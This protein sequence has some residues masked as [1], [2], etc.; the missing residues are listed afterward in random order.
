MIQNFFKSFTVKFFPILKFSSPPDSSTSL[1]DLTSGIRFYLRQ[2]GQN[3][4][5]IG[6]RLILAKVLMPHGEWQNWL[7][8]NFGLTDRTARNFMSVAKRFGKTKTFAFFPTSTLIKMLA[9]PEGDEEKFIEEQAAEGR[10]VAE[11]SVKTLRVEI[12]KY[13]A[14][15]AAVDG[16]GEG[17]VTVEQSSVSSEK[18]E[19]SV[20]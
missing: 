12:Q 2:I 15:L 10:I 8:D 17:L 6:K 20:Q 13:K 18:V 14:K 9:L 11:M 3:V 16:G 7:E 1:E 5:E 4:I 19:E